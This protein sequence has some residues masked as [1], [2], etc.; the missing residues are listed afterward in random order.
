M[1]LLNAGITRSL[2]C[3]PHAHRSVGNLNSHPHGCV[4]RA[5]P[6][7]PCPKH[8]DFFLQLYG[9]HSSVLIFFIIILSFLSMNDIMSFVTLI[10]WFLS[11][12]LIWFSCATTLTLLIACW[13]Q[14]KRPWVVSD[15]RINSFSFYLVRMVLA[16]YCIEVCFIPLLV[17]TMTQL[18]IHK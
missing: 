6:T 1:G 5:L 3:L 2:L 18:E 8:F 4:T 16:F 9:Q 15:H 14:A 10:T 12:F 17:N 13:S 11:F 7:K